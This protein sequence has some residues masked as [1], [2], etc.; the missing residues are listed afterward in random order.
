MPLRFQ[1]GS[2]LALDADWGSLSNA[3]S[4]G[5]HFAP[6]W[7]PSVVFLVNYS[8]LPDSYNEDAPTRFASCYK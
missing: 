5:V 3:D 8:S 6:P 2:A 7:T 4:H 1:A